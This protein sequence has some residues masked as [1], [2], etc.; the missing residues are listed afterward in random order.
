MAIKLLELKKYL[1]SGACKTKYV[2]YVD[3]DDA[4][5]RGDPAKAI[6]YLKEVN[7]D[8][9]LADTGWESGYECM[10]DVKIWADQR[11]R[12]HGRSH[13]Y[14]NAGVFI[15]ESQFLS[16]V[17]DASMKYISDDDFPSEEYWRILDEG[18]LCEHLPEFPKGVGCDQEILRYMNPRF[19]PRMQVDYAAR[20]SIR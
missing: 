16:E 9:L 7:C 18:N 19:Y 8:F 15:A 6:R 20:L 13:A 4:V 1:D 14:I 3:S 10:P 2:L 11:A 17:V 5:L 12:E